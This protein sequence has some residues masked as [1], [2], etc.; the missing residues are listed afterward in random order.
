MTAR[1]GIARKSFGR[2][3]FGA[4]IA[5]RTGSIPE[6]VVATALSLLV[7]SAIAAGSVSALGALGTA[8]SNAE[9]TQQLSVMAS[10]PSSVPGWLD[11]TDDALLETVTLPSGLEVTA[12][13]WSTPK[14]NGTE[15]FASMPRSGNRSD[16]SKCA[17]IVNVQSD[18]C[19]YA[20]AFHADD[21]RA[22]TPDLFPD[23]VV[24]DIGSVLTAGTDFVTLPAPDELTN[25]RYYL[26][27]ASI[28]A[29]GEVQMLQGGRILAI[30]PVGTVSDD[31]FGNV[32][33]EPGADITL[34]SP[35]RSLDVSRVLIYKAGE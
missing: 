8:S 32:E 5:D 7:M 28:G 31:Y 27:A 22:T 14:P 6:A 25:A 34:R 19:V 4:V 23:A 21:L 17:D 26:N 20:D 29:E 30:I 10:K 1:N 9:R 3:R 11:A 24:A 16:E 15:F 35:D 13:L 18:F 33:L 2:A 12:Y